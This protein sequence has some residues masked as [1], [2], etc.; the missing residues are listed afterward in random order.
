MK[1]SDNSQL[2]ENSSKLVDNILFFSRILRSTGIPIATNQV[3]NSINAI[4]S[5]GISNRHNFYY[6]LKTCLINDQHHFYIFD[7]AFKI[8]FKQTEV[9]QKNNNELLENFGEQKNENEKFS[10]NTSNRIIDA[11]FPKL[12]KLKK[13]QLLSQDEIPVNNKISYS[14]NEK[15]SHQDF[16]TM[17]TAEIV[18]AKV[19]ISKFSI[20]SKKIKSRRL[21]PNNLGKYI[22]P[23]RTFIKNIKNGSSSIVLNYKSNKLETSPLIILCDI[24]GSMSS[25]SRM[26]LHFMHVIMDKRRNVSTFL[27]GTRLTNISKYLKNHDIDL[28]LESVS[29]KVVDWSGGTRIGECI[30][31]Y[32][33]NWSK[34]VQ[35][36]NSTVLIITDGLDRGSSHNLEKEMQR[37]NKTCYKIIWLNPL[38]RY[39]KYKALASGAAAMLPHIN[40]MKKIHNLNSMKEL[41]ESLNKQI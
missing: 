11:L 21:I 27:F 12:E 13:N 1:I 18:N 2:N 32:N 26:F 14:S 28:A 15:L 9:L 38:L 41:A 37:L 25:Y 3:I 31:D 39:E 22:D 6:T 30:R 23:K 36:G 40:E 19:A 5:I 35:N 10:N 34:R 24:S 4:S 17:S 7:Q 8:L 29:K 16:E 33:K 20:E